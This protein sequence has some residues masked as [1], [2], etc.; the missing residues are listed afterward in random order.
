M[1]TSFS[2]PS[3]FSFLPSKRITPLPESGSRLLLIIV[4][5]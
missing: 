3:T 2:T 1:R 5:V 4:C